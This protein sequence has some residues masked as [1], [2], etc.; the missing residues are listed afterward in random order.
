[1]GIIDLQIRDQ[2]VT[3]ASMAYLWIPRLVADLGLASSVLFLY[4]VMTNF[5]FAQQASARN[6]G[7][8]LFYSL[9]VLGI[10]RLAELR[11]GKKTSAS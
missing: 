9:T 3:I 5:I 7:I 6:Y 11:F 4:L 1:M 10:A 2:F 8:D